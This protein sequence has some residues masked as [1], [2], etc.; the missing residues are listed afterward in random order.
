MTENPNNSG[1]YIFLS[2]NEKFGGRHSRDP[3]CS[4]LVLFHLYGVTLV[5]MLTEWLLEPQP[6]HL[7]SMQEETPMA[8]EFFR[9]AHPR[10]QNCIRKYDY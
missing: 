10:D 4:S 7:R 5:F 1:K 2:G 8:K 3:G 9:K 6:S